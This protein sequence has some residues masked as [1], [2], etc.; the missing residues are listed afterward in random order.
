MEVYEKS[1]PFSRLFIS[2]MYLS[3]TCTIEPLNGLISKTLAI[4]KWMM[5][6]LSIALIN[7]KVGVIGE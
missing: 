2:D 4:R 3:S 1:N 7:Q 5:A 6:K